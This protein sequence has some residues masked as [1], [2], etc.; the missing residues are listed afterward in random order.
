LEWGEICNQCATLHNE[1]RPRENNLIL[2]PSGQTN[3]IILLNC[4]TIFNSPSLVHIRNDIFI[5]SWI[6]IQPIW[7]SLHWRGEWSFGW[8]DTIIENVILYGEGQFGCLSVNF[9]LMDYGFMVFNAIFNNISVILWRSVL[10]VEETGVLWENHWP[11]ASHWQTWSRIRNRN[12]IIF[13][14][15][16]VVCRLTSFTCLYKQ[17]LLDSCTEVHSLIYCRL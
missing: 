3:K 8:G 6:A 2:I 5:C 14:I 13:N 9:I 16:I 1:I 7:T 12:A 11:V 10:L 15:S 4:N 17:G